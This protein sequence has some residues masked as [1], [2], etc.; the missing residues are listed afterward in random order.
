[1]KQIHNPNLFKFA[2]YSALS[3]L[4]LV[5][6]STKSITDNKTPQAR[7]IEFLDRGLIA[8]PAVQGVLVSWRLLHSDD[9]SLKFD[10]YR[11]GNKINKKPIKGVSNIVDSMGKPGSVYEL[12]SGKKVI[13]QTKAWDKPYLSIPLTPPPDGTTPDGQTYTY[14]ANDASVGDLDG[15]GQ[16][17]IILKW[18]PSNSK[19]N[20][21]GGYT[22]KVFIDAYTLTGSRLWRIDLGKN[23]RAGAHYTQFMVYDFDGDGRAEIAMKT[24]DGTV[25]GT[26]KVLGDS[27][28]NWVAGDGEY[29]TRDRT[30]S[31]V[32]A[33]GKL[34]GQL[35]G[36]I[37]SGPE[38]FT[39]FDGM[40]GKAMDSVQYIPQRVPGNDNPTAD[41]LKAVWG[42]GYANRS[43]RYLG[44]V[45]YLDGQHPSV[46][47]ARGYYGRTVVAAYDYRAGKISSRWTF[48]SAALNMPP[49]FGGQGNHQ[50]SIADVDGDGKDEII[51]GAMA[52]DDNGAPLWT[53]N[54]MHGDAMHVSDLDPTHPGLEKFGVHEDIPDNGGIG[55]A[56]ISVSDGKILWTKPAEKDTGRGV[57]FDIDPRYAGNENW[58]S[59]SPELYNIKGLVIAPVHPKQTNFAVWWDGDLLRELLDGNK[60]SKWDWEK[61]Q[62]HDVLVA[63]DCSANNGTKSTPALSA[64]ILGDWREEV[65]WRTADNKSLRIYSTNIPSEFGM[66][67]LMEDTQY[68]VAIAWQN[69][70]YNQ[71]P[72]PSFYIGP[73]MKKP[74]K[75]TLHIIRANP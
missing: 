73:G 62:A 33:D 14:N 54:L 63:E 17:E 2:F 16:Y 47:M 39:V 37:I 56:L 64:D 9:S 49:H 29:E 10:V 74:V 59:N 8:V 31:L 21:Q 57:A 46:L 3:A 30:G 35:R 69:T 51:Y 7:Q 25:D 42:D 71:P 4:I 11:D 72:H 41:E 20:S 66:P 22:G 26:G 45:A 61:S 65:I 44:A 36:R 40:S 70:A 18:D 52:I 50:M 13:A 43:E 1:M 38:Y 5:A 12:R 27:K 55:S 24:A 67:T 75:P 23:I 32:K 28:A 53:T 34:V 68:R 6:C 19:D 15:D 60:I 48:D 58:A